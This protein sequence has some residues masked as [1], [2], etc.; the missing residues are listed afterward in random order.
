ME[1]RIKIS[2]SDISSENMFAVLDSVC[3]WKRLG[4]F[5]IERNLKLVGSLR[6]WSHGRRY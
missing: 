5:V 1:I 3:A 2:Q 6:G 4:G